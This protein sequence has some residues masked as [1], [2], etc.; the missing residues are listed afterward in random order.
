LIKDVGSQGV[1]Q[2]GHFSDKG[3]GRFF[4]CGLKHFLVKKN[5]DFSK[6]MVCSH[7]QGEEEGWAS[8]DILRTRVEGVIFSRFCADVLHAPYLILLFFHLLIFRSTV[9]NYLSYVHLSSH[10]IPHLT[11][12]HG[13]LAIVSSISGLQSILCSWK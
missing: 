6:F 3:E 10:A 4:R 8:M 11:K 9:I 2:C 5:S 7:G 13:R 1:V 12:S